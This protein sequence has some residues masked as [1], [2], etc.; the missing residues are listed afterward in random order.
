MRT[1]FIA[2]AKV[3]GIIQ[4]YTGL[5]YLTS[6][7]PVFR[8]LSQAPAG[9]DV[10]ISMRSFGSGVALT[11][12]SLA[13]T[14]VLSF[15]AAWMLLFRTT[16]LADKLRIPETREGDGLA[17]DT[18]LLCGS[19]LLGLY[20]TVQATPALLSICFRPAYYGGG[21]FSSVLPPV[22]K[23]ALGLLLAIRPRLVVNLLTKGEKTQGKRII[24]GSIAVLALLIVVGRVITMQHKYSRLSAYESRSSPALPG[25]T[26]IIPRNTNT[27]PDTQWY[28]LAGVPLHSSTNGL[29]DLTN[30]P[31]VDVVDLLKGETE[32]TE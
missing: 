10:E 1:I 6:I 15:G 8:M 11:A 2:V 26:E 19:M 13:A 17:K 9:Q 27:P 28:A 25:S 30:A 21:I 14:L 24:I 4:G 31:I 7:M 5:V 3:F 16:W 18:I 23:L 32:K 29:L 12:T 20:V 22:L